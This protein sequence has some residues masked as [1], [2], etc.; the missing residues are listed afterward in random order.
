M[1]KHENRLA[2]A[3]CTLILSGAA[4]VAL[5]GY[6]EALTHIAVWLNGARP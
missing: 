1:Q 2:S 6:L 4:C 3:I 5:Y